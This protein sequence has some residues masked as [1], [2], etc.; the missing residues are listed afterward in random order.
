MLKCEQG[1]IRFNKSEHRRALMEV[2]ER[3]KGSIERK[4]MNISAVMVVLGLPHIDGYKP[5]SHYQNALFE[6]VEA[7]LSENRDLH[8]LLTGESDAVRAELLE[9]PTGARL[10]Y[11]DAPPRRACREQRLPEEIQRVIQR[12]ESPAVRDARIRALGKDGEA[13]VFEMEKRRLRCLGR[14]DLASDVRW[15]ARDEGDGFGYDILSFKGSGAGAHDK[16]LLEV[17]TTNGPRTTPFFVTSNELQV[18][19]KCP[20]RFRIVRL[21]NFRRHLRAYKLKPP[22]SEQVLLSP[23]IYRASYK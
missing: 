10:V 11:D 22:L 5:F 15:I 18:S 16:R 8:K 23:T 6:T 14:D 12:F 2:V 9:V 4:H 21:Y 3:S 17:K 7:H 1:G 13:L 20:E 19:E